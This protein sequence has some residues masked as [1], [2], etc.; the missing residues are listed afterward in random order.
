M[1]LYRP[2]FRV[3]FDCLYQTNNLGLLGTDDIT[4]NN[5]ETIVIGDSF[6]SGQGGCAWFDRLQQRRKTERLI[7]AG[8]PGTG[9]GHWIELLDYLQKNGVTPKRLLVIAI[10]WDFR[11]RVWI[12]PQSQLQCLAGGTCPPDTPGLWLPITNDSHPD[13]LHRSAERYA[14]RF[15][16]V[17]FK[18]LLNEYLRENIYVFKF[19]RRAVDNVQRWMDGSMHV[20]VSTRFADTERALEIFKALNVPLHVMVVSQ[21]DETGFLGERQWLE[22]AFAQ[23]TAHNVA[24]SWCQL[25]SS[26][27]LPYD[28]HPTAQGYDRVVECADKV[29]GELR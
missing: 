4:P 25:S 14:A 16:N 12:W 19:G 20:D 6:T 28:G 2:Q 1:N 15:G 22:R 5:E 29:L 26:D 9:F 7:N 8:L 18:D 3:E 24:H 27:F 13:M 23:L 10:S 21:R 11:R 17:R